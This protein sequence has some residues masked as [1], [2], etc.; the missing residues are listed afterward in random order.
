MVPLGGVVGVAAVLGLVPP[1]LTLGGGWSTVDADEV[2]AAVAAPGAERADVVFTGR[3]RML[4][5][6]VQS[7]LEFYRGGAATEVARLP[8]MALADECQRLHAD[9]DP[10]VL[11]MLA[12]VQV[13]QRYACVQ[14]LTVVR[15]PVVGP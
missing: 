11:T 9:T 8:S 12:P 14:G 15:I 6:T 13:V 7:A 5:A 4:D 10:G 1:V 2:I 3:G